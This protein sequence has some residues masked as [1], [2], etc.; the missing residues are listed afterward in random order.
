[1][2]GN[3]NIKKVYTR[4]T[5]EKLKSILKPLNFENDI[6]PHLDKFTGRQWVFDRIDAWLVD[7][8]A[9]RVFWVTGKPGVGKTAI[10]AWLCKTRSEITAFHFCRHGHKEK[11]NP[12]SA[13]LSIAY[14]LSSQL[15][16]YQ[17]MLNSLDLEKI[18]T[19]ESPRTIF[20]N[21]IVQPLTVIPRPG[22]NY[23][24][25]ID[26]LDEATI[27]GK[28]E[29]ASFIASEFDKTPDWL[30]LIITSRPEPEVMHPLQALTPYVL[31]ASTPENEDDIRTFLKRELRTF[32]GGTEC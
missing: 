20:D 14:Q 18:V 11:S 9:S 31:D 26:A 13:I 1:V 5:P 22:R 27:G 21:L 15:P 2:T 6:K 8:K 3:L 17:E 25:L 24:V 30:R 28:N 16:D 4:N 7:I 23:V 10:S 32:T 19:V 29:L 12:Q